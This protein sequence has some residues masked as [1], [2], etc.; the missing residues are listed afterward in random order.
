[1]IRSQLALAVTGLIFFFSSNALFADDA[2]INN[3][4]EMTPERLERQAIR[5][6][7]YI[8]ARLHEHSATAHNVEESGNNEAIALFHQ[9]R[10]DLDNIAEQINQKQ[11]TDAIPAIKKVSVSIKNIMK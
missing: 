9:A 5:Q 10:E 6:F 2:Y 7:K 11:Y 4:P 3:K 1:M 8:N